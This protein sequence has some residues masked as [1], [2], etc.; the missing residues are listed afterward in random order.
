MPDLRYKPQAAQHTEI[1]RPKRAEGQ[2][3]LGYTE[4]LNKNEQSKKDDDPL[5]VRDRILHIY[6]KRGFASIDPADLRGRFRWMG[7]Y[8][9]RAPGFDGGKTAMLEEEEL[10]D[11]YFMLR[12]RSDGKLLSADAVRALVPHADRCMI[13]LLEGGNLVV[14]GQQSRHLNPDG[15]YPY[16]RTVVRRALDARKH[17]DI[18]RVLLFEP[19][20]HADMYG[21]FV[22]EPVADEGDIGVVF[23]HNAGYSTACGHGTI[24][25]VTWAIESGEVDV[26][27]P[28]TR[29]VPIYTPQPY[30]PPLGGEFD[31]NACN[32]AAA[33]N[34]EHVNLWAGTGYR[35]AEARPAGGLVAGARPFAAVRHETHNLLALNKVG[36]D[37]GHGRRS[38]RRDDQ[39]RQGQG[40]DHWRRSGRNQVPGE[41]PPIPLRTS[42][43]RTPPK[44]SRFGRPTRVSPLY[45]GRP[46]TAP[47]GGG[48]V[49]DMRVQSRPRRR[50]RMRPADVMVIVSRPPDVRRDWIGRKPHDTRRLAVKLRRARGR[51]GR[52][53]STASRQDRACTPRSGAGRRC[54]GRRCRTRPRSRHPRR[55]RA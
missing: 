40:R 12:V 4:P 49:N 38:H 18:R 54:S 25:L 3:A 14:R 43:A 47:V 30:T 24:A 13:L 20:G 32:A 9:Q 6:S 46:L 28:E 27:E 10:D 26:T 5:N 44:L 23:F 55:L 35:R 8:T 41:R 39:P 53:E 45:T 33:G 7:L 21:C 34:P 31:L 2:W 15:N 1:P 29:V 17:D 36:G 22:T 37:R 16:S 50:V 11:R 48:I 51:A 42:L 52:R 19:R